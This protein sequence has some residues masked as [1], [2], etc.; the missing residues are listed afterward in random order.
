MGQPRRARLRRRRLGRFSQLTQEQGSGSTIS[1]GGTFDLGTIYNVPAEPSV[2]DLTFEILLSDPG[3]PPTVVTG[4]VQFTGLVDTDGDGD[5]DGKDFLTLQTDAPTSI[6]NWKVAYGTVALTT[7]GAA[8]VP[9]PAS[10]ALA[11]A[12]A[13]AA[14]MIATR[15]R[16][17]NPSDRER[18]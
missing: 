8:A 15:R 16:I 13:V 18:T 14:A 5:V 9:E 3:D 17:A 1:P 10:G 2:E 7:A 6:P 4:L 12:A 11:M